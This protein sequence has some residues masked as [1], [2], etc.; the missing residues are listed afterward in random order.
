MTWQMAII[1]IRNIAE[2]A[3]VPDN[4]DPFRNARTTLTNPL[5]RLFMA[6]YGVNYHVEHH[7]M[8]WVPCYNLPKAR[9]YLLE[10]G[11]GDRMESMPGYRAVIKLATSR[12]DD[13]D[14]RGDLVHNSRRKRVSGTFDEGYQAPAN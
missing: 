3:M 1:R 10:N 6:P 7:L 12:P 14:R 5:T 2:H 11:F 13:E 4:E 8:M 9:K